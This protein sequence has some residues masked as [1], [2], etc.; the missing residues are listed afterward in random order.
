MRLAILAGV[1]LL[2]AACH[3]TPDEQQIRETMVSMEQAL[4]HHEPKA[5]MA[6][7]ADDFV[8]KDAEFDRAALANLLR[9]EVLSN[10]SVGV[11]LGPIDIDLQGDRASAQ[12]MATFTGGSG[13]LLP[14]RG[15][16]YSIT[17]WWKRQGR[18]WICYSA[19]WEQK[20]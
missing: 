13:G 4:E 19:H 16:I 14:E 11:A 5:F 12:V 8:G 6:H 18:D 3:R 17:S 7:I 20:L 9:I 15:S 1:I 2:T 10:E